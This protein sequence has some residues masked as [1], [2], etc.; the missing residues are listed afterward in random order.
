MSHLALYLFGPPR[1]V[2][3]DQPIHIPRRKATALLAY[4][5]VSDQN[6]SRDVLATLLW[7]ENDQGS[8]RAEL[9]RALSTLPCSAST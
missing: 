4:L 5:A 8:A 7:M 6:H 2:L 3:D 1:L 9:R